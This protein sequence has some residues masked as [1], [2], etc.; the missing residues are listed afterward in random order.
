MAARLRRAGMQ[1]PEIRSDLTHFKV[2]LR[3]HTLMDDETLRWLAGHAESG[4]SD[5]QKLRSLTAD[6][7]RVAADGSTRGGCSSPGM[8]LRRGMSP[9]LCHEWKRCQPARRP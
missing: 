7:L 3:N 8:P 5:Q 1:P 4:L 2:I 9:R 6:G